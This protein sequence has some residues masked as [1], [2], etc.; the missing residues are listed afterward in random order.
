MGL[1]GG[2]RSEGKRQNTNR[3]EL[4]LQKEKQTIDFTLFVINT[5]KATLPWIN[6]IEYNEDALTNDPSV[7]KK[8]SAAQ[9][10]HHP[11]SQ[12]N[13]DPEPLKPLNSQNMRFR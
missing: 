13:K 2:N 4:R 3:N 5:C 1:P 6:F 11:I 7:I 8:W 10:L 12:G 9:Q